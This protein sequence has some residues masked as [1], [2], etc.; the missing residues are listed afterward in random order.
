MNLTDDKDTGIEVP[1]V[2]TQVVT[3]RHTGSEGVRLLLPWGLM[4]SLDNTL[5]WWWYSKMVSRLLTDLIAE[6]L[7]CLNCCYCCCKK[8]GNDFLSKMWNVLVWYT[9]F[10]S[11]KKFCCRL[12]FVTVVLYIYFMFSGCKEHRIPLPPNRIPHHGLCPSL[13]RQ[14][15]QTSAG[16]C[17]GNRL[18]FQGGWKGL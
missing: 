15:L 11:K 2:V 16:R 7:G 3:D 8:N 12:S 9:C 5:Q 10:D 13:H 14:W 4:F 18:Y 6:T 1:G 17:S